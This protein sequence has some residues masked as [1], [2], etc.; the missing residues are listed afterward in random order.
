MR[1][2]GSEYRFVTYTKVDLALAK[3]TC[4]DMSSHLLRLETEEEYLMMQDLILSNEC[5]SPGLSYTI[6]ET[7]DNQPIDN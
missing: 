6:H 4:A 1:V 7:K 5:E 3:Q 2:N